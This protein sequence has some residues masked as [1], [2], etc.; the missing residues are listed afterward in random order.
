MFESHFTDENHDEY[1]EEVK[2]EA[3]DK[4]DKYAAWLKSNKI[5]DDH[6]ENER[7]VRDPK[8]DLIGRAKQMGLPT[9][10]P[11][12]ALDDDDDDG[13]HIDSEDDQYLDKQLEAGNNSEFYSD[14]D[15]EEISDTVRE[16]ENDQTTEKIRPEDLQ[17]EAAEFMS[18]N[19]ETD[20][21]DMEDTDLEKLA[22]GDP[23]LMRFVE[24][25][26]NNEIFEDS[27]FDGLVDQAK[28]MEHNVPD[29]DSFLADFKADIGD[30]DDDSP[31]GT[32]GHPSG[33]SDVVS[34]R[35]QSSREKKQL[36]PEQQQR[37]DE[38]TSAT[39]TA[40][41]SLLPTEGSK[42]PE[43]D[44]L[45][46]MLDNE[47]PPPT[48]PRPEE[49]FNPKYVPQVT[50][51]QLMVDDKGVI[52]KDEISRQWEMVYFGRARNP[53]YSQPVPVRRMDNI[54]KA[55][56][57]YRDMMD[58]NIP[59]NEE[60][61]ANYMQ[62]YSEMGDVKKAQG[63]IDLFGKVHDIKPRELT[64]QALVRMNIY[65]NNIDG[66]VEVV[67]KMSSLGIADKNSYGM[68]VRSLTHRKDIVGA[69]KLVEEAHKD[70]LT[71]SNRYVKLLRTTCENMGLTHPHL[72]PDPNEWVKDVKRTR[73]EK[74]NLKRSVIQRVSSLTFKGV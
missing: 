41:W 72:I 14:N 58:R 39:A 5:L 57:L 10:K 71:L 6:L 46:R 55:E 51:G 42:H 50:T 22:A 19:D 45:V 54:A 7:V 70:G 74:K 27:D 65:A 36:T 13:D 53:D 48:I 59:V 20:L 67:R 2:I 61:L 56:A 38:A 8:I 43:M 29:M 25:M 31:D 18:G 34:Q 12:P 15:E 17:R 33:F 69:L 52:S 35:L 68:V 9:S 32:E 49:E 4:E 44:M 73:K 23:F 30:N 28:N 37:V 26:K 3:A 1:I 11:R 60:T 24:K 16:T 47:V 63:V 62:V 40:P 21:E 64:H 66:A